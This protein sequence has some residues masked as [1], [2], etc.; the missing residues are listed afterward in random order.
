MA[1]VKLTLSAGP[2]PTTHGHPIYL[3]PVQ[4]TQL[5]ILPLAAFGLGAALVHWRDQAARLAE[6]G[7]AADRQQAT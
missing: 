4:W 5:V 7:R 1:I 2:T 3:V 6:L